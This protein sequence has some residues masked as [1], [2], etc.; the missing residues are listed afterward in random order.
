MVRDFAE[1]EIRPVAKR[2]DKTREFPWATVRRAG[3]LGLMG[4][5]IPGEWGGAGAD[6]IS[7]A[8][9]A[10]EMTRVCATHATILGANNSLTCGPIHA[11]GT[12]DQK[13]RY[14]KPLASGR[15]LGAYS[16]S[17]PGSGSDAAS[18]TT[19]ARQDGG[20]YV[21]NGTKS[22]VTLGPVADT[23]IVFATLDPRLGAKGICAFI[24]EKGFDGLKAG[25]PEHKMGLRASPTSNLFFEDCRVP[26]ENLLGREGEGFKI[27]L[28]TLD[29]G[30][31]LAAAGAIGIARAALE[32]SVAYAKERRQFGR[33]IGDFQAI[34]WMLADMAMNIE[35]ARIMC[36]RAAWLKD[37]KVRFT[38]EA[39][40]A[41][42]FATEMATQ[43]C[44]KA[45]QIHGGMGYTTEANVERYLR[46]VKVW[47]IFEGTSE[48]QRMVI[49]RQLGLPQEA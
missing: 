13:E 32:D 23:I 34:Q 42:L 27:A 15:H 43:A 24:V 16:L 5:A 14:L 35:T 25:E 45:V 8:I 48:I 3:E 21:L 41:K 28:A 38:K 31:V 12:D 6:T 33:P 44:L 19:T 10:E 29:S 9:T 49:A 39:S 11:F 36:H 2:I 18:L 4:V 1:K 47:E 30:R 37:Q 20:S 26:K 40:I 46:D 17:E 7:Y 22:W